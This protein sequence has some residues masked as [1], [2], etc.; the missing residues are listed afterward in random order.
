M[1][2]P[3]DIDVEIQEEIIALR[4]Q[5]AASMDVLR[6]PVMLLELVVELKLH[7]AVAMKEARHG[8]RAD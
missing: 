2:L 6:G 5:F 7:R 4:K 1:P 8:R 3:D